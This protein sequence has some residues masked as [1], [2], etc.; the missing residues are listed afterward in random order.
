MN[1]VTNEMPM[2]EKVLTNLVRL[3][4][5]DVLHCNVL[6]QKEET[7]EEM[8]RL[9]IRMSLNDWN[10]TPPLLNGITIENFP[11]IDW[12]IIA[13]V[14][15]ILQ[16]AGI[17]QYRNDMP[18]NDNGVTANP[19]TKG[20]QYLSLAQM[21]MGQLEA[22]KKD[23]KI[24]Y[25]YANTFGV[26][27]S[28]EYRMWDW[29]GL[30][31]PATLNDYGTAGMSA[32]P[33]LVVDAQGLGNNDDKPAKLPPRAFTIAD[34]AENPLANSYE[35]YIPHNQ[36]CDVDF[37]LINTATQEDYRHKCKTIRFINKNSFMFSVNKAPDERFPGEIIIFKI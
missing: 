28:A 19:W 4:M 3:F 2:N 30:Y 10:T 23:F 12:L 21:Y 34:W 18:F 6:V 24:A 5:R 20:P 16:S 33:N 7:S 31:A 26:V 36:N 1:Q 14:C 32:M 13:S 17:M 22:H 27:R 11:C 29:T 37:R 25:N 35:I 15:R 8:I 9:A